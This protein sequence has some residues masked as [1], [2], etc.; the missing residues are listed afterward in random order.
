VVVVVMKIR[1]F[2]GRLK[3]SPNKIK[4]MTTTTIFTYLMGGNEI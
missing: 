3:Y 1:K 4:L 2:G